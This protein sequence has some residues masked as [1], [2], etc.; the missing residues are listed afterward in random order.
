M[1]LKYLG[2]ACAVLVL[3]LAPGPPAFAQSRRGGPRPGRSVNTPIDEFMR[4][5]PAERQ[6]ALDRLPPEQRRRIQDRLRRFNALPEE[7]QQE[8]KSMYNRLNQLPAPQQQAVRRSLNQFSQ[9]PADRKQAIRQELKS[10][11]PLSAEERQTRL[12]SPKFREEFN[13][14]EQGIVRDMSQ[15]LPPK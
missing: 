8:L 11:A 9:Q 10:M 15:L 2:V 4:M 14:K 1:R 13:D 7:R 12:E 5:S 6:K 3:F